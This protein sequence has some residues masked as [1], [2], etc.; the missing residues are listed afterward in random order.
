MALSHFNVVPLNRIHNGV[1]KFSELYCW[2][3]NPCDG[4]RS[5]KDAGSPPKRG[6]RILANLA[7]DR[8]RQ[9]IEPGNTTAWKT[10]GLKKIPEDRW[11][12]NN[13]KTAGRK[14]DCRLEREVLRV[15]GYGYRLREW[16]GRAISHAVN[17][18][19]G[20]APH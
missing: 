1:P 4:G 10:A 12:K 6:H 11:L 15:E 17:T 20:L 16:R 5:P 9:V 2:H 8:A 13:W 7:P 14:N 19:F 3:L 18:D